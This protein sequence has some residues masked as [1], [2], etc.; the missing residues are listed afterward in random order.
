MSFKPYNRF[1]IFARDDYRCHYCG[2][3]VNNRV[4]PHHPRR[5]T[6]DHMT[7]KSRGGAKYDESNVVTACR[8]CNEEKGNMLY[9]VY[10]WFRHM[11]LRGHDRQELLDAIAEVEAE[12]ELSHTHAA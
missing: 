4:L 12:G 9:D 7:P 11:L 2:L 5:A 6:I 10:L 8:R 3:T 1:E